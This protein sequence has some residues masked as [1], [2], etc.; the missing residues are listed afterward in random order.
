MAIRAKQLD[1][2]LP[3]GIGRIS[4]VADEVQ[5]RAAWSLYVE[6]E[7]RVAVQPLD[8]DTGLLREAL[9]SLYAIF[10]ITRGILKEAG[11]EV[12]DGEASLG[13][14]AIR[15]LNDGLRPFLSDWHPRLKA[16]EAMRPKDVSELDHERAWDDYA[17]MRAALAQLQ[18]DLRVYT[19]MLA[20]ISGAKA[21]GTANSA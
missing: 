19:D 20:E 6:L 21:T 9:N 1:V 2:G 12:A 10:G 15:V 5:Q 7:T 4:F 17:A 3:F 8:D 11:P 13:P 16:H 18:A 14:I